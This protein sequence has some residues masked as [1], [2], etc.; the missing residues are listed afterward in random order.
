MFGDLGHGIIMFLAGLALVVFEK[1]IDAARIKGEVSR[2]AAPRIIRETKN[3]YR[4]FK[5]FMAV[6]T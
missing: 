2:N 5:R 1:K 6:A 3:A 4:F